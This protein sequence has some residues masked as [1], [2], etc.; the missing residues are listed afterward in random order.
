MLV[1]S[2][3]F[4]CLTVLLCSLLV[5]AMTFY[6]IAPHLKLLWTELS[7]SLYVFVL[8]SLGSNTKVDYFSPKFKIKT[9]CTSQNHRITEW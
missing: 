1:Y 7:I 4:N 5:S 9:W 3:A 2:S 6:K 8:S